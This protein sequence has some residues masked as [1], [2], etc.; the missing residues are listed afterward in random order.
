MVVVTPTDHPESVRNRCVIEVFGGIFMLLIRCWIF[1]WYK[2]FRHRSESDLALFLWQTYLFSEQPMQQSKSFTCSQ[3]YYSPLCEP[4]SPFDIVKAGDHCERKISKQILPLLF[5]LGW[6]IRV[7][8]ATCNDKISKQILPLLFIL[9]WYIRVVKATCNDKISK[10][11]L[12]LLFILGWYIRVV[13]A[14]CNNNHVT[15]M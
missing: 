5:I 14:T 15:W 13:N 3:C 8:K 10:Q 6:Y 4:H 11:I 1:C 12:P 9:G 2:G 7:V